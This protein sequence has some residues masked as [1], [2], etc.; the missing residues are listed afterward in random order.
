MVLLSGAAEI[1]LVFRP[2]KYLALYR[3]SSLTSEI[4]KSE[5]ASI[6]TLEGRM[7][8]IYS[9]PLTP[10]TQIKRLSPRKKEIYLKSQDW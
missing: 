10:N 5:H 7:E 4:E 3:K 9:L 6:F 2:L 8:I 1:M